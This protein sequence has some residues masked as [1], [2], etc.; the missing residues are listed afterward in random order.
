MYSWSGCVPDAWTVGS[1]QKLF[2]V[3]TWGSIFVN[4]PHLSALNIRIFANN[5]YP[6]LF[7]SLFK[8]SALIHSTINKPF[9]TCVHTRVVWILI[10]NICKA[11]KRFHVQ[12]GVTL[13]IKTPMLNIADVM[14]SNCS[15]YDLCQVQVI[16]EGWH[17]VCS[18]NGWQVMTTECM[19]VQAIHRRSGSSSID[20]VKVAP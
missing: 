18:D 20:E 5:I 7:P 19:F 8:S 1:G 6:P 3:T 2:I 15:H 12:L 4:L 10:S 14:S 17:K 11:S 9:V 13:L 16:F